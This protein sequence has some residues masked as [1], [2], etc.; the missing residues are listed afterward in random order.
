VKPLVVALALVTA[1]A[2]I[3]LCGAFLAS[4]GVQGYDFSAHP[5]SWVQL[6]PPEET[7]C[8]AKATRRQRWCLGHWEWFGQQP[9]Y[10]LKD[11]CKSLWKKTHERCVDGE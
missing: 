7:E 1:L 5:L 8:R 2:A 3:A 11:Q 4:G 10:G 9:P 6:T